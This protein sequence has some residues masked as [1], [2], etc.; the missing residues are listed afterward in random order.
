MAADYYELLGVERGASD[1]EIKKAFRVVARELHPD[2]NRHDPEAEEKFKRAASAYEVLSDPERRRV[3]DA[4]GEEGLRGGGYRSGGAAGFGSLEDILGSLFGQGGDS[5][6]GDTF[7]FGGAGPASGGDI[8]TEIEITL[9][10]V[11][12]GAKRELSFEAVSACEHC[13]GNGAE[14]GTPIE[15]CSECDGRGEVRRVSRTPFGQLVRAAP[16]QRCGGAGR[17]PKQPCAECDGRGRVA[18]ARTWD[19]EVPPGIESGQ[20]IRITGAG[21]A[22]EAGA[23]PGDLYVQVHVAEDERFRRE[24]PDLVTMVEVSATEAMLGCEVAAPTLDGEREIEIEPGTQPGERVVL[25]ALG[26]PQLHG[27]R[28]GDQHVFVNV[29]VPTKLSEEQRGIAERLGETLG[30]DN[31][32]PNGGQGLFSR[33]RRAFR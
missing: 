33:F 26:L 30:P 12:T 15:T 25:K 5:M 20:R 27:S 21:H 3:Y 2:V 16:C 28:R 6:F 4:F 19:V 8:G 32:S 14:P 29:V 31:F 13:R 7:G 10:E 9:A 23:R 24:G 18:G 17:I 11:L 22:G 1:A